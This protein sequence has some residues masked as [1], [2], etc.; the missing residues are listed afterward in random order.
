MG[1]GNRVQSSRR[2]R[3][4]AHAGKSNEEKERTS[5]I[6]RGSPLVFGQIPICTSIGRNSTCLCKEQLLRGEEL[7]ESCKQLQNLYMPGNISSSQ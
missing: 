7:P 3:E 1:K 4:L 5:E 6:F 2:L